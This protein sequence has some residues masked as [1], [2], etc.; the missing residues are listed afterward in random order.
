MV[1]HQFVNEGEVGRVSGNVDAAP[2][3]DSPNE[4]SLLQ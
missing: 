1:E 3:G 2:V 4:F